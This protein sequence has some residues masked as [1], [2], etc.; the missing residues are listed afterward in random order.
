MPHNKAGLG[1][2]QVVQAIK[3]EAE[4]APELDLGEE[5]GRED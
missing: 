1:P 3:C 2:S 5:D 4:K